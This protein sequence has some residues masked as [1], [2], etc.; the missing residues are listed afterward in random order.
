MDKFKTLRVCPFTYASARSI[1]PWEH[2][3]IF[4]MGAVPKPHEPDV[5]RPTSDHTASG[6]NPA[7][8]LDG[9]RYSLHTLK[10]ISKSLLFQW[11]MGVDDVADAFPFIPLSPMLWPFFLFVWYDLEEGA[12][13]DA[14]ALY[15]HLFADFGAS[16]TP[17]TW[18]IILEDVF[19]AVA[20]S[21]S[22]ITLS[23]ECYVDDL[24]TLGDDPALVDAERA[25]LA[26][27]L[28]LYGIILKLAKSRA[29]AQNQLCLGFW[30]NSVTRTR[31]LDEKKLCVYLAQ[32][33]E[34]SSRR[35]VTLHEIQSFEGRMQRA[36]M[37]LP[38]GASCLLASGYALMAHLQRPSQRRRTSAAFRADC[39]AL[40]ELLTKNG[41]MG[42]FSSDRFSRGPLVDT[43]AS[44]S[45][46]YTGGGYFSRCGRYR[47]W[48]Y[49]RRAARQPIDF[50]EGDTVV[51]AMCD[52]GH[53]W[54]HSVVRFRIDNQAFQRSA[55]KGH[56]RAERLV[57]LLK[58]TL[59]LSIHFQCLFEYDWVAT[60]LNYYADP[61]SRLEGESAFFATVSEHPPRLGAGAHLV[62]DPRC[63]QTKGAA[64]FSFKHGREFSSDEDGNAVC[65]PAARLRGGGKGNASLQQPLSVPYPSCS[66]FHRLPAELRTRADELIAYRLAKSSMDSIH[67]ALTHWDK[68]RAA[69]GWSRV[70][71]TNDESRGA[72]LLAF[73]LYF[74]HQT[75]LAASSITNYIWGLRQYMKLQRQA[76]PVMGVMEWSDFM[77][78]MS[79]VCW[80]PKEPRTELPVALLGDA[81]DTA[82][83][84]DFMDVQLVVLLLI[85]FF[86]FA[87]SETPLPKNFTG[88]ESFDPLQ[89]LR[90]CD[91]QD[92]QLDDGQ[93]AL[94]VR[95]KIIKQDSKMERAGAAAGEDWVYIGDAPGVF[96]VRMWLTRLWR[97]WP[98]G[99]RDQD[100]F[101]LHPDRV[102]AWRYGDALDA[103]R[104]LLARV[105]DLALAEKFGLHSVRVAGWN[106]AKSGPHGEPLAIA[107]GGWSDRTSAGRYDRFKLA[108]VVQLAAHQVSLRGAAPAHVPSA[109]ED[110]DSNDE[111][112]PIGLRCRPQP[113]LLQRA[114]PAPLD[115]EDL[116]RRVVHRLGALRAER[117]E[118]FAPPEGL[119]PPNPG[120]TPRR[121]SAAATAS[122]P[123]SSM[124][125]APR[126]FVSR[127]SH[128]RILPSD[129]SE[130]R[131]VG[132]ECR[133]RWSP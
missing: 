31:T 90:V 22:V 21:E 44:K 7:S 76:D 98:E 120:P 56:S 106:T 48:P 37:T 100:P 114:P 67:A 3:R 85:L 128:L 113:D 34:F 5:W 110:E 131:R 101:F 104:E 42:Y 79:I 62:R 109:S 43:D 130:E 66:V 58:Q 95:L 33:L 115:S 46:A 36:I 80:V 83:G 24:S 25:A 91:V 35:S 122:G 132:K 64:N 55:V 69:H 86:S 60:A 65:C 78:A 103:M 63:G 61:L 19:L 23:I 52:L 53:L 57:L 38:P 88:A 77:Q 26:I 126:D 125:S 129:R 27:W 94:R 39:S 29:A 108:W 127:F 117:R 97:L 14:L 124:E 10:A 41:G 6:L 47:F 112:A 8:C 92:T 89:H 9:L 73:L 2:F 87:R 93:W 121:P 111:G 105:V 32:L 51:T 133:S 40:Y 123:S 74:V 18:K 30:W 75:Q 20:R 4:P 50:L 96:S 16:G 11:Y 102:R 82:D 68:V 12:S 118:G 107:Q 1:I 70:I 99:R 59:Y 72:K 17:G 54:K 28:E 13:S 45:R 116:Q 81:L 119:E 15:V 49:S 84:T 71:R